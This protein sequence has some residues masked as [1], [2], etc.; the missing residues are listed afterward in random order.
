MEV[1][2][3]IALT[4]WSFSA[5]ARG[6]KALKNKSASISNARWLAYTTA[7]VAS[8][9]AAGNSAEATIHYSGPINQIFK[10]CKDASFQ[11]DRPGDFIRLRH[12]SFLV[13]SSSNNG[14]I[15]FNVAGIAEA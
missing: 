5:N 15:F 4:S 12:S 9:F 6:M 8:A 1:D 13:C 7:G 11:L 2:W 14:N 10:A 3:L